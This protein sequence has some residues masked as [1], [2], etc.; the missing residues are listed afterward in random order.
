MG[1]LAI[2]STGTTWATSAIL[3][4]AESGL[5]PSPWGKGFLKIQDGRQGWPGGP[6]ERGVECGDSNL[7]GCCEAFLSEHLQACCCSRY[8]VLPRSVLDPLG[9]QGRPRPEEKER[10]GKGER[11]RERERAGETHIVCKQ[12]SFVHLILC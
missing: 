3:F 4:L 12:S 6:G 1:T 7:R 8:Q 11:E 10:G 5:F 9:L 2:Y